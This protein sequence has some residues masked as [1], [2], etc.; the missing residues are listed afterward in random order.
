M[1]VALDTTTPNPA[2]EAQGASY[3]AE[4]IL[5]HSANDPSRRSRIAAPLLVGAAAIA[6]CAAVA[7][8]NPGDTGVPLCWS[9]SVFGVD[10]PFCGGL[11]ATNSLLRIDPA[12][13][14]DHN[15]VLAIGLPLAAIF[16]VWILVQRWRGVERTRT[17]PSWIWV[18]AA[19][20]L[21]AFGVLRN[22]GG[23]AWIRW[24]Y[25]DLYTG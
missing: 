2:H 14:L 10:C 16:W 3:P 17:L 24:M 21:V 23:P 8:A 22:F 18:T 1:P 25:S 9:R 15:F 20:L 12:A 4:Q 11:R 5:T 7:A 19:V 6:G 13:A